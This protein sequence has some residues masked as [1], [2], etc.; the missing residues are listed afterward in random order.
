MKLFIPGPTNVH[1]DVLAKMATP[2]IGH[3]TPEAS[4][5]Q[6]NI[7]EKLRA[8]MFTN[9]KIV[10]STSSGTGLMEG[11]IRSVTQKKAI[12]FS[13][14]AFGKRWHELAVLN[15][16]D[17]DLFEATSGEPIMPAT[18]D[19]YLKTGKY[20]TMAITHSETST[21][22]LNPIEAIAEVVSKYPN[23]LWLVDTVSSLG[24]MRIE[25]DKLGIDV[26]I[27]SSQKALALPPG[28]SIAS[29]S[30][31][32]EERLKK[33]GKRGFY[34]DLLTL[35]EYIDKRNYQYNCTPSLP[36]MFA[37]DFQLDRIVKEGFENRFIRHIEMAEYMINWATHFFKVYPQ[38]G[39][40]AMT[41]TCV[42]NTRN[43]DVTK[44]NKEL[45]ER[46]MVL[47]NGY[48]A[49]KDKTFRIGHMG[50]MVLDDVVELTNAMEDILKLQ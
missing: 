3:R 11:S 20:D 16:I 49:L 44:L 22:V 36:H 21:G 29:V 32:A 19:Q 8:L 48:G 50:D 45:I 23:V 41:V 15:G 43:I 38:P 24:G 18:V 30:Q 39:F 13:T 1:P 26:C 37:L 5:L 34:L 27:S 46:K 17:A 28:L 25:V 42:E 7:S 10:L 9:N 47:S 12:V 6:K 2:M 31:R 40:E 33:I 35:C 4:A 14:G